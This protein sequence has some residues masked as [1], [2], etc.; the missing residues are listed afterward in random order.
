MKGR[1]RN[2][3]PGN[4]RKKAKIFIRLCESDLFDY[5]SQSEGMF[6]LYTYTVPMC[7]FAHCSVINSAGSRCDVVVRIRKKLFKIKTLPSTYIFLK[8]KH[9]TYRY[10]YIYPYILNIYS[11]I[12]TFCHKARTYLVGS[13]FGFYF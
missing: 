1:Q 3:L 10:T 4:R 12:C 5:V 7:V 13:F 6:R 2:V 11:Y 8:H 9:A